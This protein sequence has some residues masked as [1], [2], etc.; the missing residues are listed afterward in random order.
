MSDAAL[1]G[2]VMWYSVNIYRRLGE[3]TK[4]QITEAMDAAGEACN[5]KPLWMTGDQT[6]TIPHFGAKSGPWIIA[7]M[8]AY[9][10]WTQKKAGEEYL[11]DSPLLEAAALG[12]QLYQLDET[13]TRREA[14]PSRHERKP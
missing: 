10:V 2:C 3:L 12:W 11:P 5:Q 8:S 14:M 4:A 6:F 9:V 13:K 7:L 1:T